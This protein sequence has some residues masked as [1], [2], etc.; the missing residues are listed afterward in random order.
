MTIFDYLVLFVL[1][2]SVLLGTLR[3]LIKEVLSLASWLLS[4]VVANTYGAGLAALLPAAVPGQAIRLMLAFVVLFIGTRLLMGLLTLALDAVVEA[5]GL[6]LADRGLG[7]AFGLARGLLIVLV[8]V[9]LC[10]MTAIPRQTFWQQ[11]RFSPLAE[12]GARAI[13]PYLPAA[14]AQ[15]VQF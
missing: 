1:G 14:Y 11:A 5:T 7:S 2:C 15:H 4:C 9:I 13:K 3:G 6:T 10:G 12:S 8:A